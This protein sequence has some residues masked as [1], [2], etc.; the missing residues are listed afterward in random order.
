MKICGIICEYNPFHNGHA[1]L[2]EQAKKKSDCDAIV[3]VMSG[4]FT[5][6]GELAILDK[7]T[8]AEHAIRAGADAVIELPAVY[9]VAPAEIFASGAIKLL[10]S[11]PDFEKLAFGSESGDENLFRSAA[12]ILLR[13]PKGFKQRLYAQLRTG[14]SL[15]RAKFESLEAVGKDEAA[16]I[17]SPN[18]ILGVEYQKALLRMQSRAEILPVL[19]EGAAHSDTKLYRNFSSASAIRSAVRNGKI[20]TVKKNIPVYVESDLRNAVSDVFYKKIALYSALAT[21]AEQLKKIVDCT[22]GL[23][24]RIKSLV[25][26]NPDYDIFIQKAT[27]KRYISSRIQ[28]ILAAAVIGIDEETVR[29]SLR[30]PLYLRILAVKKERAD[31]MLRCFNRSAYPVLARRSDYLKLTKTAETVNEKDIFASELFALFS[32]QGTCEQHI[33]LI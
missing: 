15:T 20:K 1:F 24:N 2:I 18:N 4:N 7:Y 33:R 10:N 26:T 9:A 28:R 8:R 19:R 29:K 14:K 22:E 13:E 23:E 27:T 12:D 5:Q 6:R 31:E 17:Q 30:A 3:C 16:L 21:P 25:K 11:L 32:G